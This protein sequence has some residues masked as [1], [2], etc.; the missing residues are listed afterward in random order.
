MIKVK[1]IINLKDLPDEEII[2][3]VRSGQHQYY[4]T[5]M[6]R[7]NQRLYRVARGMNI[8]DADCDDLIQQTFIN[9][10]EKLGQ[11]KGES[12]FS[13]W[14]TRI[15]INQC[16]M[17]KRRK[18]LLI[19]DDILENPEKM[20]RAFNNTNNSPEKDMIREEM[21]KILEEA[22]EYLPEDFRTVYLMRDVE[23]MSVKETA[24]C[25]SIS[26]SNVKIRLF[27][28]KAI[29]KNYLERYLNP[30]DIF[31]FGNHRCDAVVEGVM[32]FILSSAKPV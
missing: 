15:L 3:L 23:E 22:I 13:T 20:E 32:N 5:I 26:E 2:S 29:L 19:N 31:E 14:L 16:L 12:K 7:Y 27:R 8:R 28:A 4:E 11:F 24:A 10:F 30:E 18:K 6:R 1:A 9:A 21:K 17:D 25:L